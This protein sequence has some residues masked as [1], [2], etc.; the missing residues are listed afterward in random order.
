MEEKI[1]KKKMQLLKESDNK[2]RKLWVL[3]ARKEIPKVFSTVFQ[4]TSPRSCVRHFC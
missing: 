4:A 3:I 2:R 1:E